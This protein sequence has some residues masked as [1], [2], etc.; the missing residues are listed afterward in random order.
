LN[1]YE[2][3]AYFVDNFEGLKLGLEVLGSF[4]ALHYFVFVVIVEYLL[5]SSYGNLVVDFVEADLEPV[6]D[7][8]VDNNFVE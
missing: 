3:L 8:V 5:H 2:R 1:F 6:V 7:K 4:D